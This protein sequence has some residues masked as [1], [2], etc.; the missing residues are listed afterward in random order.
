MIPHDPD[1]A[2]WSELLEAGGEP[3]AALRRSILDRTTRLVRRRRRVRRFG[4]VV[5]LVACYA[6]GLA[7]GSLSTT[8]ESQLAKADKP[9]MAPTSSAGAT[10]SARTAASEPEPVDCIRLVG[11]QELAVSEPE[12]ARKPPSRFEQPRAIT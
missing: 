4:L 9:P 3:S 2:R 5:A 1:E 12:P 7:S 6:A 10:G 11:R 8:G